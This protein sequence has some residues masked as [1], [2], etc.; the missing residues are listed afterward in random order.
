MTHRLLLLLAVA[1]PWLTS[2]LPDEP[3]KPKADSDAVR[4]RAVLEIVL[5]DL[6]SCP[7]SGLLSR[8]TNKR[9]HFSPEA[10]SYRTDL[11]HV[12][13]RWKREKEWDKLS[14]VQ[15]ALA[16]Q[17]ARELIRRLEE[18]GVFEGFKPKDERIIIW[19]KARAD[20]TRDPQHWP[21]Q[22]F[23]AYAPGYSQDR[24]LAIVRLTF[25][26]FLHPGHTTYILARKEGKWVV[27]TRIVVIFV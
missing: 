23:H 16:Q 25:D 11:E 15:F 2:G 20:A 27:L 14:P 22:V 8:E 24:Q 12:L 1:S 26:C 4:D 6:L 21:L 18:K 3:P 10:P 19:D 7:D 13:D 5:K 17:A 9:I